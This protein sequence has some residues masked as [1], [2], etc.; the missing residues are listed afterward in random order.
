MAPRAVQLRNR[1]VGQAG[2]GLTEGLSAQV[3]WLSRV[4]LQRLDGLSGLPA[5]RELYASF[6]S[7][8]S[9]EPLQVP[10]TS[11]AAVRLSKA[12]G[13]RPKPCPLPPRIHHW[14]CWQRILWKGDWTGRAEFRW[15]DGERGDADLQWLGV[16]RGRFS[17]HCTCSDVLTPVSAP[18][19]CPPHYGSRE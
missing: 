7:I 12:T 1:Q 11:A 6:N 2:R 3:L 5:L 18:R 19:L 16:I 9:L 17:A 13:R 14:G 10:S 8:S 4:G 15:N